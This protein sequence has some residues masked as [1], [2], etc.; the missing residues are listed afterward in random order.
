MGLKAKP[1]WIATKWHPTIQSFEIWNTKRNRISHNNAEGFVTVWVKDKDQIGEFIEDILYVRP[2]WV[3]ANTATGSYILRPIHCDIRPVDGRY[4]V[5]GYGE[6]TSSSGGFFV[7]IIFNA[8]VSEEVE[9]FGQR[10]LVTEKITQHGE[11]LTIDHNKFY[12]HNQSL[13]EELRDGLTEE[14]GTGTCKGLTPLRNQDESPGKWFNCIKVDMTIERINLDYTANVITS[15]GGTTSTSA[16]EALLNISSKTNK[17]NAGFH[18]LSGWSFSP[19][20]IMATVNNIERVNERYGDACGYGTGSSE[21]YWWSIVHL[22]FNVRPAG[23]NRF[24][25]AMV[26]QGGTG[27]PNWSWYRMRVKSAEGCKLF[28]P[29]QKAVEVNYFLDTSSY[30]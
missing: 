25:R 21:Y 1:S 20:C 29:Y 4:T 7:D 19:E 12:W 28:Y 26:D 30:S 8:T 13:E 6:I 9:M 14:Y 23:W 17:Y 22:S 2:T 15:G 18:T 27:T 11:F 5:D 10:V 24:W 3:V 16:I